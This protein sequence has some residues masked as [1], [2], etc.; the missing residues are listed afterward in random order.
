[1]SAEAVA[2]VA[3]AG[4]KSIV[5]MRL[6]SEPGADV[7]AEAQAAKAAG[8]TYIHLPFQSGSPD[9]AKLDEFLKAVAT[10]AHQPMLLHCAGGVRASMFWA[11]KRVMVDAWT[12]DKALAELPELSRNISPALRAFMLD[13]LKQHGKG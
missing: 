9:P 1:M 12:V 7:E 3:Q 4:F 2:S 6:A 5:N 11:V 8:L 10:P 13:Y